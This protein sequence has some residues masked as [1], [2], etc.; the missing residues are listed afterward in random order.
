M[1]F[2]VAGFFA[3][4]EKCTI[5]SHSNTQANASSGET[6]PAIKNSQQQLISTVEEIAGTLS[7]AE[8]EDDIS[9]NIILKKNNES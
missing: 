2:L 5:F 6:V 4:F 8:Q 1:P 3:I 9:E 7:T